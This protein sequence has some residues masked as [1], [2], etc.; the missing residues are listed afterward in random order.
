MKLDPLTLVS[1]ALAVVGFVAVVGGIWLLAGPG[2]AAVAGGVLCLTL[3]VAL[4]KGWM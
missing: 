4:A 1:I 3:G 2:W